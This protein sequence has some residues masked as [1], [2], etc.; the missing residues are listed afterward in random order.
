MRLNCLKKR[1][2]S[3]NTASFE[4]L[5]GCMHHWSVMNITSCTRMT[6]S[7][8]FTKLSSIDLFP[9]SII[10]YFF[11]M[12]PRNLNDLKMQMA[13]SQR[14]DFAGQEFSP[15]KD[16]REYTD[17]ANNCMVKLLFFFFLNINRA[18]NNRLLASGYDGFAN[19][20][21]TSTAVAG[22]LRRHQQHAIWDR[23]SA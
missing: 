17:S 12:M 11:K 5:L 1:R 8:K 10:F 21:A 2:V 15:P 19:L 23:F 6:S 9:W 20:L 3:F 4:Y 22:S 13:F 7:C 16:G 18:N 14:S